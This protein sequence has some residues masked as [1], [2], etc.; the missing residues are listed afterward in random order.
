MEKEFPFSRFNINQLELIARY[1]QVHFISAIT[2]QML[3]GGLWDI[4]FT[5]GIGSVLYARYR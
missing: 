3:Q 5:L 1:E 4:A 2:D